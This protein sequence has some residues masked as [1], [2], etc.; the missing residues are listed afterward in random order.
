MKIP[1]INIYN[2]KQYQ[3][4]NSMKKYLITG[5]AGF[6]GSNLV[7]YLLKGYDD[8]LIVNLD[9]LT[10]AGNLDNIKDIA[11]DKRHTFI[12]GDICNKKLVTKLFCKYDFDYVINL[13]AESHVDRSIK[14]PEIFGM[15]NFT[16]TLNMLNCTK[17]AWQ[18]NNIWKLGKKF[19][20]IS[21]DE[22]Y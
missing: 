14:E 6:V 4:E 7:K 10:Y 1:T 3:K 8:I 17:N 19:I 5:G 20:Q 9:L 18:D 16:G 2:F 15:T 13:A 21:T 22:V 12:K 11:K